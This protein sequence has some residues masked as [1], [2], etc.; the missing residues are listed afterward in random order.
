LFFHSIRP[1]TSK[2]VKGGGGGGIEINK[3]EPPIGSVLC[4]LASLDAAFSWAAL[5]GLMSC[6]VE[7]QWNCPS[8]DRILG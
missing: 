1:S 4:D 5:S 7:E 8:S 3:D 6:W 2:G